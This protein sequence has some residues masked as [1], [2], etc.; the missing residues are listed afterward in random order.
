M[1]LVGSLGTLNILWS[2]MLFPVLASIQ[3]DLGTSA[4]A[5]Q[6]TVSL[7]FVAN[8]FMCLWHGVLSDAWGRRKPLFIGLVVLVL[9]VAAAPQLLTHLLRRSS[10]DVA[11]DLGLLMGASTQSIYNWESGKARPHAKF[12]PTIVALRSVGKKQTLAHLEA[13]RSVA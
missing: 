5:V 3:Q 12:L 10:T 8:A 9:T 4:T 13:V 7:Y 2:D 6:Q 11:A 1:L